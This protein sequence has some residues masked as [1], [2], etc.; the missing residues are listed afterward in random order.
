MRKKKVLSQVKS[1]H[2]EEKLAF[3]ALLQIKEGSF[4]SQGFRFCDTSLHLFQIN[5]IL[6]FEFLLYS[7]WPWFG[8]HGGTMVVLSP[9]RKVVMGTFSVKC[10]LLR[11]WEGWGCLGLE[12]LDRVCFVFPMWP[13]INSIKIDELI[14]G[15]IFQQYIHHYNNQYMYLY[16]PPKK[17]L[18]H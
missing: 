18:F 15:V 14:K 11:L 17:S 1:T 7:V 9:S 6:T 3:A 10:V 16:P 8:Q 4:C 5:Q 13:W 2:N 12:M